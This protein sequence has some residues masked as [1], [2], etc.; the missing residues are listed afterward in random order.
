MGSTVNHIVHQPNQQSQSSSTTT[1]STSLST[2]TTVNDNQNEV[3]RSNEQQP[4][5]MSNHVNHVECNNNNNGINPGFISESNMTTNVTTPPMSHNDQPQGTILRQPLI[6]SN[7]RRTLKGLWPNGLSPFFASLLC[8]ANF[9]TICRFSIL[10][11]F[12]KGPFLIEFTFISIIFGLPFLL[13]LMV[14]G[15]YLGSGY[16][17]MW[18]ISPIFKGIGVAFLFCY[19]IISIY[20]VIPISWLLVYLRDSFLTTRD[21]AYKWTYCNR[22]FNGERCFKAWNSSTYANDYLGWSV[23]GYY[24]NTVLGQQDNGRFSA[25]AKLNI[26]L[27][28]ALIWILIFVLLFRGIHHSSRMIIFFGTFPF[29]MFTFTIIRFVEEFGA[30]ISSLFVLT[31]SSKAFLGDSTSWYLAARES[32]IVWILFG[33]IIQT[34]YASSRPGVS[35]IKHCSVLFLVTITLLVSSSF[36]LASCMHIISSSKLEYTFSSFEKYGTVNFVRDSPGTTYRPSVTLESGVNLFLGENLFSSESKTYL[37][38]YQVLRWA[39]EIMP[40]ALALKGS[41][42][43]S[44]FWAT[45]FYLSGIL[46]SFGSHLVLW[47]T[48]IE[49]I[50]SISPDSLRQSKTTIA[51]ITSLIGFS[52]SVAI[53]SW[54]NDHII[55]FL[56]SCFASICWIACLY[57]L[58]VSVIFV[59]RGKPCTPHDLV[60]NLTKDQKIISWLTPI[61]TFHWSLVVTAIL[62][63]LSIL[64]TR[65]YLGFE[66]SWFN[67]SFMYPFWSFKVAIVWNILQLAPL[68]IVSIYGLTLFFMSLCTSRSLPLSVRLK[69]LFAPEITIYEPDIPSFFLDPSGQ[70]YRLPASMH[71]HHPHPHHRHHH[72]HH[73]HHHPHYLTESGLSPDPPPKYSPPPSYSSATAK[74]L[75]KQFRS[76]ISSTLDRTF[77]R[78]SQ[79]IVISPANLNQL[80]E[81]NES[82]KRPKRPKISTKS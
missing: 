64:F 34:I 19:T 16:L 46:I 10:T 26:I 69:D 54:I 40:L 1:S 59:V 58:M 15:Q 65:S 52:V 12:L 17:D 74:P 61:L 62:T 27:N 5:L 67:I 79:G 55:Y 78:D 49:A 8:C 11:Y 56:D 45:S 22:R 7:T 41:R 30:G 13:F 9:Y 33:S 42:V 35:L 37:S 72:H 53:N 80:D 51:F 47:G 3:N 36:F 71:G 28:L 4:Q 38:Q 68:Y 31:D 39:T 73:H 29:I 50:I 20:S 77:P 2:V 63:I 14:L 81:T 48:L 18:F 60:S 6:G 57:M 23:S 32:F 43:I 75:M 25:Y 66:L 24:H 82:S 76:R 44:S 70:P 21:S